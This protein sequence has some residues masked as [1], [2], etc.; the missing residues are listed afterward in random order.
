MRQLTAKQKKLLSKTMEAHEKKN[1]YGGRDNDIA[2]V[3][4]LPETVWEELK[5]INDTEILWQETNRFID[6][7][8]WAKFNNQIYK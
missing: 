7:W 4:T 6:D 3:D 5:A 2:D 1:F 8:R